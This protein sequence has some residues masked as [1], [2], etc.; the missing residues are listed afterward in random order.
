MGSECNYI[1]APLLAAELVISGKGKE[2]DQGRVDISGS[3]ELDQGQT[4]KGR[5]PREGIRRGT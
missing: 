1:S 3:L 5:K 4:E 2:V